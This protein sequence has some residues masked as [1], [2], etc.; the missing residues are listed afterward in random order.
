MTACGYKHI[1]ASRHKECWRIVLGNVVLDTK[2]PALIGGV[3]Q[4]KHVEEATL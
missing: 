2:G 4:S 3:L 1:D